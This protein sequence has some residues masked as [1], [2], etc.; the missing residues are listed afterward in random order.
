MG[1]CQQ[2]TSPDQASIA[3]GKAFEMT[4]PL[5]AADGSYR[6]FLTRIAPF[7]DDRGAIT[8]WF[9]VNTDISEQAAVEAALRVERDRSQGVLE[10][11][12]EGFLL[13]DGE[14]RRLHHRGCDDAVGPRQADRDADND[15]LAIGGLRG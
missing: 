2:T 5:R 1:V 12:R 13:L 7:R 3:T 9:G 8:R 4:F 6:P 15:R 14:F 11:I 10:N